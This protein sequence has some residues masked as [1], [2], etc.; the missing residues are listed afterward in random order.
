[1]APSNDGI[2]A[3]FTRKSTAFLAMILRKP[4]N[5]SVH[6][7]IITLER[8]NETAISLSI[9]PTKLYICCERQLV[10]CHRQSKAL[11]CRPKHRH[12][13]TFDCF[14]T[15][16]AIWYNDNKLVSH[17]PDAFNTSVFSPLDHRQRSVYYY[18]L[19]L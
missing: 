7:Y 13:F 18:F 3:I 19:R 11:Q 9:Y 4:R 6:M 2:I 10:I 14:I 5:K 17:K 8:Y 1:M 12:L 16:T 15:T